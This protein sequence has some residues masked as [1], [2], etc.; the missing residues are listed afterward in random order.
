MTGDAGQSVTATY[1]ATC[2]LDDADR[3]SDPSDQSSVTIAN[4]PAEDEEGTGEGGGTGNGGGNGTGTGTGSGGTTG[5]S[6]E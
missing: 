1:T 6:N 5:G 4:A 2:R 3:V